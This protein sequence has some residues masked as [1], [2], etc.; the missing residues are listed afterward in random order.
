MN[1]TSSSI[2]QVINQCFTLYIP[3]SARVSGT[4]QEYKG[5]IEIPNL[6]DE[7]EA[8]EVDVNASIDT[9]GPH[10]TQIRQFFT[11]AGSKA[12]QVG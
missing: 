9:K 8:H 3:F 11:N 7:N 6:S 5:N 10:E 4:E 2:L 1:G 12:I